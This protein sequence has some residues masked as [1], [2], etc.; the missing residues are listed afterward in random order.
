MD[1]AV[2]H[3][4]SPTHLIVPVLVAA[5]KS[6]LILA[7]VLAC[8][9]C[10]PAPS[11]VSRSSPLADAERAYQSGAWLK[12]YDEGCAAQAVLNGD[13]A[14]RAALIAGSAAARLGELQ[15][16]DDLL[17]DAVT[18][19]NGA[20]R[21]EALVSRASVRA[22]VG[23]T[24]LAR[25]DLQDAIPLLSTAQAQRA[26]AELQRLGGRA[27]AA[28]AA[29]AAAPATTTR[30]AQAA[31]VTRAATAVAPS[32]QG[33]TGRWLLQAGSFTKR[34]TAAKRAAEL[35]SDCARLQLGTPTI[36]EVSSPTGGR[37][38]RVVLGV[39]S[40]RANAEEARR[41]LGRTDIIV[42]AEID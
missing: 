33:A 34:P 16:A 17:S 3:L 7:C 10:E 4:R 35:A 36:E 5:L 39:F 37:L 15:R 42:Q 11:T 26:R 29:P 27:T 6:A 8:N 20:I 24:S 40:E 12:A 21:G 9:G 19:S 28:P 14:A 1:H 23:Q 31:P 18:S 22:S 13:D 41:Q 38:Y 30:E 32:P 2:A 25:T